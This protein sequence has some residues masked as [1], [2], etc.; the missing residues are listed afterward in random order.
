MPGFCRS[1]SRYSSDA[2]NRFM[3]L[4]N[5]AVQGLD[6]NRKQR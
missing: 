5:V 1:A 2:A 3:H 4:T 6:S